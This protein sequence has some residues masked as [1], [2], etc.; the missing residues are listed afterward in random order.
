MGRSP[1]LSS[2][3]AVLAVVV[4]CG[5]SAPWLA[6]YRP[7]EQPDPVAGRH[8]APLTAMAAVEL[9]NGA[10][11]LADRAERTAEGLLIERL[12]KTEVLPLSRVRNLDGDGVRDR[13]FFLMGSDKYSRDV[14]SRWLY[15]ARV[16]LSIAGLALALALTV[17]VAVGAVSALGGPILD[18]LL[19]RGVD[20]L[21]AFPWLFLIIT[22]TA[23]FPTGNWSLILLL[24]MTGWMS[25]ARLTRAEILSLK[26][27]DFV[28]AAR[29]LGAG[30]VHIFL[31]HLLPNAM[32]PLLVAGALRIGRLILVE[33]SL[34]FL[35]FGVQPPDASW[36]N[37]IAE[38]QGTMLTA[39][40]VTTF[41]GLALIVTVIAFSLVSDGLRDVLDPRREP[42]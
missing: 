28:H 1:S 23:L 40:W 15:G 14:F 41:P 36:G 26:E 2:G 5:F 22:L 30:E 9:D 24:G 39:W 12:G 32:T 3:V 20:G 29:G 8:R 10:W 27:R 11:L 6:P 17:G 31:R 38:G 33:A 21:L 34:S 42:V 25:I 7:S 35:G 37:M 13:R 19:M 4:L 18:S 16:S